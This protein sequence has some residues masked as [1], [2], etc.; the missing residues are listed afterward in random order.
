MTAKYDKLGLEFLYPE[1][2]KLIDDVSGS[3]QVITLE[4]PDGSTTWSVHLYPRETDVDL[5]LKEAIDSLQQTYEDIEISPCENSFG[6]TAN[7]GVE[8]LFYCLDF[9]IRAELQIVNTEERCLMFWTQAEDRDYD[10]QK[11]VFKAI[12]ISLLQSLKPDSC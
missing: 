6:D 12:A 3:P 9:L 7:R 1:N 4:T 8:A 2:W 5:I 10:K 11:L